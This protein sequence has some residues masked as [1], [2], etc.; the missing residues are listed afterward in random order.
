MEK[1][2]WDFHGARL[3]KDPKMRLPF[4]CCNFYKFKSSVI[5]ELEGDCPVEVQEVENLIDGYARDGLNFLC[6]DYTGSS[7]LVS[8]L[9]IYLIL[10]L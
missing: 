8:F 7:C 9:L 10:I 1:M 5:K 2:N 4:A 6:G 3:A